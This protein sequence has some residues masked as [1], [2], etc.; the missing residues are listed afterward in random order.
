MRRL[1]LAALCFIATSVL[2]APRPIS[3]AER[4]AVEM[5]ADYLSRGPAAIADRL[6]AS[7]PLRRFSGQDLLDEIET[8]LGP[9]GGARWDLQTVVPALQN[10]AAV[11]GISYPSGA[12]ESVTFT[13]TADSHVIDIR[14]LAMPSD[15]PV[16]FESAAALPD[17]KSSA[18]PPNTL[19]L[20]LGLAAALIAIAA[21]FVRPARVGAF[22]AVAIAAAAIILN[23]QP[24]A[25]IAAVATHTKPTDSYP[26]LSKLLPL[27][28]AMTAGVADASSQSTAACHDDPCAT[29]AVLW[30]AQAELQQEQT[31]D[32]ERALA[33]FSVPSNIPLAEIL[34][35]R[36]SLLKE[37]EADAAVAFE[38]AIN[39]GPGRDGLWFETADALS[40]LGFDDSAE[41][42]LRRLDRLGSRD[43]DVYYS[44]ALI[45]A[46][47]RRKEDAANY[48]KQAW[49]MRPVDRALLIGQPALWATLRTPPPIESISLSDAH[50]PTF[51][52]A[53]ASSRA[54]HLPSGAKAGISGDYLRVQI[55]DSG[56]L[57]PGGAALAPQG[58]PVVDAGA[59]ARDEDERALRDFSQLA[60][61]AHTAAAFSSPALRRRVL[62]TA[63][64][65]AKRNRW[66]DLISLTDALSPKSEHVPAELFFL[67]NEALHHTNRAAD[68]TRMIEELAASKVLQ[69]KRDADALERLGEMLSADD[70]FDLAIAMYDKAQAIR[71]SPLTDDRVRQIQ[72][73]KRLATKYSTVSSAH[74]EVH[75]PEDVHI[76]MAKQIDDILEAELARL[77][78]WV[79]VPNFQKVIV[80]VVWWDEFRST[81][82]GSDF[83]LGFYNG[84]I[85]VPLAGAWRFAPPVVA[86]MSHELCH[87]M[88]AQATNDQAPHWFHE[89][90][91]QRIEMR[92][93]H[94]NAF[95]MY[96]DAH[97]LA[98][99]LLD[100]AISTSP[101]PEVI[102]EGYIESQ[103]VIRYIEAK[104]GAAGVKTLLDAF[105]SG[106]TNEEAIQKLTG[107]SLA[108]FDVSLREWG[109]SA[110]RVFENP[111]PVHYDAQENP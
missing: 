37:N 71:P 14:I 83:I 103:T 78:K 20:A 55:G 85:T 24:P 110:A 30:K 65:L 33:T 61:A 35:G 46:T 82:T 19:P 100:A 3:D 7:S 104:Y 109:H 93:Y 57:V 64:A 32:A 27:R 34:R 72:M 92:P 16:L 102:G 75:Y 51:A 111:E 10:K 94:A 21:A 36:A 67:R 73:N 66:A 17:Q 84:K 77:Q 63:N 47:K 4:S 11:F 99:S 13:M 25:P 80:N 81:Y 106:A 50:E 107:K 79:P 105:R 76:V 26:H 31:S 69:R 108:D 70:Q 86:L 54:I 5:A 8:R 91:A 40:A 23:R 2:A 101:D 53:D 56:L 22:A 95:N 96:D 88:I 41:R 42:Y 44:L 28:R 29:A 49:Q 59:W 68:G 62:R 38:S 90:L 1:C 60:T 52:A 97:L 87:A 98:M 48:L 39:L 89:G 58:T 43:A 74:F 15:R 18:P 45:S 9:P 12:D 6:D